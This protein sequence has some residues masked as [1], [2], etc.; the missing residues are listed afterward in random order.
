M[1]GGAGTRSGW[2]M[3]VGPA[4]GGERAWRSS[5][6]STPPA[7]PAPG[8][9]SVG[10]LNLGAIAAPAAPS[11]CAPYTFRCCG[12]GAAPCTPPPPWLAAAAAAAAA[13]AVAAAASSAAAASLAAAADGAGA[14][15]GSSSGAAAVGGAAASSAAASSGESAGGSTCGSAGG[16]AMGEAGTESLAC[17]AAL[18][19]LPRRAGGLG[20]VSSAAAPSSPCPPRSTITR[21]ARGTPSAAAPARARAVESTTAAPRRCTDDHGAADACARD[22]KDAAKSAEH[23]RSPAS[24]PRPRPQRSAGRAAQVARTSAAD[25]I[26]VE[27]VIFG[28]WGALGPR[29]RAPRR[30]WPNSPAGSGPHDFPASGI[31]RPQCRARH[32]RPRKAAR[33][34]E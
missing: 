8:G 18:G 6:R 30:P 33:R 34:I 22:G 23:A 15:S 9:D 31:A 14:A 1:R 20:A 21:R 5:G 12:S 19:F 3:S 24:R 2:G 32:S 16:A 25:A 28:W 7:P 13:A 10:G 11:S 17:D 4:S 26:L 29:R 27:H